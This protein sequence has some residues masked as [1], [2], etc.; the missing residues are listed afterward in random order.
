MIFNNQF[1]ANQAWLN[2]WTWLNNN[3]FITNLSPEQ[4]IGMSNIPVVNNSISLSNQLTDNFIWLNPINM[5]Q[6]QIAIYH[7]GGWLMPNDTW[8]PDPEAAWQAAWNKA[9]AEQW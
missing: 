8:V 2:N 1:L 9:A 6:Q 3:Q 7:E 4:Q 5:M